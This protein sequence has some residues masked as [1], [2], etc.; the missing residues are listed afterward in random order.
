MNDRI[1]RRVKLLEDQYGQL[2]SLSEVAEVLKYRTIDS[3]RKAHARGR[4]P[5]NLYKFDGRKGLFAKA[6]EVAEALEYLGSSHSVPSS[7]TNDKGGT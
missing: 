7:P 1:E 3:L 4:L 5:M 6:N 2:L